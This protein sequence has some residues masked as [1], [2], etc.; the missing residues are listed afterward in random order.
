M[1]GEQLTTRTITMS[2]LPCAV[3]LCIKMQRATVS[4]TTQLL[5]TTTMQWSAWATTKAQLQIQS[6]M[7]W[8]IEL[9]S[10]LHACETHWN[11]Q[12]VQLQNMD[13]ASVILSAQ[14][15]HSKTSVLQWYNA[16]WP[17][18]WTKM[19]H[20]PAMSGLVYECTRTRCTAGVENTL[21][22]PREAFA[23]CSLRWILRRVDAKLLDQGRIRLPS[24][25]GALYEV[26]T[27]KMYGRVEVGTTAQ[28]TSVQCHVRLVAIDMQ[29]A[30]VVQVHGQMTMNLRQLSF[31][32]SAQL[33]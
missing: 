17:S 6:E 9:S 27:Y 22:I 1:D 20:L 8:R 3:Y 32:G 11:D 30:G 29:L 28:C 12:V 23:E 7:I 5:H 33:A 19:E 31:M 18:V 13:E 10:E 4:T 26:I 14:A 24:A 15:S 16:Q 2:C 21:V 25:V